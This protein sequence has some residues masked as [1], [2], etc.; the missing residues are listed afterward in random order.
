MTNAVTLADGKALQSSTWAA[1]CVTNPLYVNLII[2]PMPTIPADGAISIAVKNQLINTQ[3]SATRIALPS[4]TSGF[5]W[6]TAGT[7]Y[8][9][10]VFAAQSGGD[11]LYAVTFPETLV[12]ETG[13]SRFISTSLV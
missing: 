11:P 13:D 8:G 5:T 3:S 7:Y 4:L 2:S 9:A 10:V 1:R 6:Q 12:L